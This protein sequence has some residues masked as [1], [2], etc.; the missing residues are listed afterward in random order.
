MKSILSM[1]GI[2]H[3]PAR[4]RDAMRNGGCAKE[5]AI[6]DGGSVA[7][8]GKPIV[9]LLPQLPRGT[10]RTS[11]KPGKPVFPTGKGKRSRTRFASFFA[12]ADGASFERVKVYPDSGNTSQ[13]AAIA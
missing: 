6:C 12:A 9:E 2:R 8:G 11:G 10:G 1:A 4:D 3:S 5:A 7:R 13:Q